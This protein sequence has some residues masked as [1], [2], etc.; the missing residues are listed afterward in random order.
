MIDTIKL[1]EDP[2]LSV[3]GEGTYIGKPVIFIRTQGCN[4]G[5]TWC[6]SKYTWAK[7]TDQSH[8]WKF[9]DLL[10]KLEG[11]GIH[12]PFWWTGGEPLEN[13][14]AIK[15]F[16]SLDAPKNMDTEI[17]S[18][19]VI[20]SAVPA[21]IEEVGD[22][23]DHMVIDVKLESAKIQYDQTAMINKYM[24]LMPVELKMVVDPA[25]IDEA[26]QFVDRYPETNITLQ[27]LYWDEF[28]FKKAKKADKDDFKE[29]ASNPEHLSLAEWYNELI[30]LVEGK[31]N[32]RLLPQ[33]HKMIW[34]TAQSMI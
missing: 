18:G 4:V 34:P 14:E 33:L 32:V 13:W 31:N 12:Y 25:D 16:L 7:D 1:A 6:D 20:I 9:K 28:K 10:R 3:N 21:F 23:I 30:P 2:Y 11:I 29:L 8:D 17:L 19:D 24:D 22:Y 26:L 15:A 27:P 5:C